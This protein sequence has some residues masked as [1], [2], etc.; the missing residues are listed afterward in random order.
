[1]AKLKEDKRTTEVRGF[2]ARAKNEAEAKKLLKGLFALREA[3][4]GHILGPLIIAIDNAV[5][6]AVTHVYPHDSWDLFRSANSTLNDQALSLDGLS[7]RF[8]VS[9]H[10]EVMVDF[11][12]KNGLAK[13]QARLRS[14]ANNLLAVAD[15]IEQFKQI[16]KRVT[17]QPHVYERGGK[18]HDKFTDCFNDIGDQAFEEVQV[19]PVTFSPLHAAMHVEEVLRAKNSYS[20]SY[21]PE[22]RVINTATGQRAYDSDF[23]EAAETYRLCGQPGEFTVV[24]YPGTNKRKPRKFESHLKFPRGTAAEAELPAEMLLN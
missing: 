12:A 23:W 13:A 14:V 24:R 19:L 1:M 20:G 7:Q 18:Y 16:R 21:E 2:G 3:E 5:G 4:W 8:E 10:L 11:G 9:S 22:W 6:E 15:L 17:A